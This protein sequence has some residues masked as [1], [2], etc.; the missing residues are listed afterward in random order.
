MPLKAKWRKRI[1][2]R[3][4]KQSDKK[5]RT[6]YV[7]DTGKHYHKSTCGAVYWTC[8]PM[9]HSIAKQR[10]YKACGLC[11]KMKE[12][13]KGLVHVSDALQRVEMRNWDTLRYKFSYR[14]Q[15]VCDYALHPDKLLI[16]QDVCAQLEDDILDSH[17]T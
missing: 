2:V 15:F 10:G 4:V 13:R 6:V 3:R 1:N 17:D 9:H 11:K 7:T 16:V 14:C 5:K 12:V 8:I